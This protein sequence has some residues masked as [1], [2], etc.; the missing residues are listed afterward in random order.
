MLYAP[1][2]PLRSD[3]HHKFYS[4]GKETPR[5]SPFCLDAP[6][7]GCR[8]CWCCRES[9][10]GKSTGRHQPEHAAS[11]VPPFSYVF[12]VRRG[13]IAALALG[14][15]IWTSCKMVQTRV[16]SLY[17]FELSLAHK[18]QGERCDRH[19]CEHVLFNFSRLV[20]L[21]GKIGRCNSF[22]VFPYQTHNSDLLWLLYQLHQPNSTSP[23]CAASQEG[24]LLPSCCGGRGQG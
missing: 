9:E 21:K 23:S 7:K 4:F 1:S 13:V 24:L 10:K 3:K 14:A 18:C 16:S 19:A 17:Y 15:G 12:Q 11:V 6:R 5:L 22:V 8:A 20:S 2:P